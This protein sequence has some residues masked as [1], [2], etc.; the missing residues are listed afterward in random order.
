M[1]MPSIPPTTPR[2]EPSRRS[3]RTRRASRAAPEIASVG[4]PVQRAAR[5]RF[6]GDAHPVLLR[7]P[8]PGLQWP[9]AQL[10]ELLRIDDL[11]RRP[12]DE[13]A[14]ALTFGR[15]A[16]IHLEGDATAVA[17]PGQR[18]TLGRA[19]DDVVLEQD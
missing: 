13:H 16:L 11:V 12:V 7:R 15:M 14:P 10:I 8:H 6:D 9:R 4:G 2:S 17:Q 18:A 19:E 1:S 5:D 3:E